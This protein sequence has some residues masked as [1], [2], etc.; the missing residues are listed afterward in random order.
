MKGSLP[1]LGSAASLVP[2]PAGQEAAAGSAG[3][4]GPCMDHACSGLS[5]TVFIAC[6]VTRGGGR[7]ACRPG[8]G[9]SGHSTLGVI[10]GLPP[11]VP[12]P[13]DSGPGRARSSSVLNAKQKTR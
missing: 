8:R 6:T 11:P 2:P 12:H 7:G 3:G 10:Q 13:P 1:G 5:K 9:G 4:G